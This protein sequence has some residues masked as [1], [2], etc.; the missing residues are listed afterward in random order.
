LGKRA[1]ED[2]AKTADEVVAVSFSQWINVLLFE[3]SSEGV[4]ERLLGVLESAFGVR[5]AEGN[6]R[7]RA[8]MVGSDLKYLDIS[9]PKM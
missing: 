4:H 1:V 2:G 7:T 3:V 8:S 9:S 6:Q 5:E